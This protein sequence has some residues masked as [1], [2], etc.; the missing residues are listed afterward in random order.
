LE[1]GAAGLAE[2]THVL[3]RYKVSNEHRYF[4]GRLFFNDR[5]DYICLGQGVDITNGIYGE[6]SRE[7]AVPPDEVRA[8]LETRPMTLLIYMDVLRS[9]SIQTAQFWLHYL[10]EQQELEIRP[11]DD[12][13]LSLLE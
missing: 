4:L 2:G 13:I 3:A 5:Q 9:A 11:V 8:Y 10:T 7:Q 12:L 6:R 1:P